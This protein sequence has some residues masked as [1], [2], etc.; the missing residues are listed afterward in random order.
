MG[1]KFGCICKNLEECFNITEKIFK[2]LRMV[3]CGEENT[4]FKIVST[5][6]TQKIEKKTLIKQKKK[7]QPLNINVF[8]HLF[9][10][11]N[12]IK[13]LKFLTRDLKKFE[14]I[15]QIQISRQSHDQVYLSI[16][17]DVI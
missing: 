7:Q 14:K 2:N 9:L 8:P 5:H 15:E 11:R 10:E 16:N 6:V 17:P 4:I 13:K 3:S 12:F 1:I